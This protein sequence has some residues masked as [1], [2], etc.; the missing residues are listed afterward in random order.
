[1]VGSR[2]I[3][4]ILAFLFLLSGCTQSEN[5]R[6]M[7]NWLSYDEGMQ[8][9]KST[10]KRGMIY[11][12]SSRYS[13][14]EL[15]ERELF[16]N[17][18]VSEMMD[19][20]VAIKVDVNDPSNLDVLSMYKFMNT[21]FPLVIF[22]DNSGEELSK[23][24]AY[25][26][27]DPYN[28]EQ[29][30]ERFIEV[31]NL[32]LNGK[33]IGE[34]LRFITL[35]GEDRKLSNYREK[36]VVLD[37]MSVDCPACRSQMIYLSELKDLYRDNITII[38]IDVAGDDTD[39]INSAFNIYIDKWLFGIDLYGDATKYL[40]QGAIPTIVILDEY[41]RIFYLMAGLRTTDELVDLIESAKNK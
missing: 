7:I 4:M 11:F 13:F 40:L 16:S 25:N 6:G 3:A 22:T 12:C 38:S 30:I 36:I 17:K 31:L 26:L 21:P 18:T 14:C 10:G 28:R 34:D 9:I 23:L 27:Y 5:K 37:L 33:I 1:M 15:I 41:G 29:S 35:S 19:D 24:I 20:F 32:T 8:E 39:S 2:Y